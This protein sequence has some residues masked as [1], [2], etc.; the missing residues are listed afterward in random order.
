MKRF[1]YILI[2]LLAFGDL[3][4][5]NVPVLYSG[6]DNGDSNIRLFIEGSGNPPYFGLY[7][8]N[9]EKTNE[10]DFEQ[11]ALIPNTANGNA[12]SVIVTGTGTKSSFYVRE[13]DTSGAGPASNILL[14]ELAGGNGD[15]E[16]NP[17]V[18]TSIREDYSTSGL[19]LYHKEYDEQCKAEFK[20]SDIDQYERV[21]IFYLRGFDTI[22]KFLGYLYYQNEEY[23]FELSWLTHGDRVIVSKDIDITGSSQI[24]N[25]AFVSMP[26]CNFDHSDPGFYVNVANSREELNKISLEM[27]IYPNPCDEIINIPFNLSDAESIEII[28]SKAITVLKSNPVSSLKTSELAGGL[29]ILRINYKN[30]ETK[31]HRFIKL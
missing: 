8:I 30:S 26:G 4:G 31:F 23:D 10:D 27:T 14:V 29:Y 2:I 22:P 7:Y 24:S 1:V 20:I 25:E 17:T 18:Y 6:I 16:Y 28:D 15:S 21:N 12:V 9:G 11:I 5:Q 19:T 13:I 3:F